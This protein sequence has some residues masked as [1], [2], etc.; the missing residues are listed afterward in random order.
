[1]VMIPV[2][3]TMNGLAHVGSI[4]GIT[5][6]LLGAGRVDSPPRLYRPPDGHT[7]AVCPPDGL[8]PPHT[9]H[10]GQLRWAP[11]GPG[12]PRVAPEGPEWHRRVPSGTDGPRVAPTG[13]EWHRMAPF[14]VTSWEQLSGVVTLSPAGLRTGHRPGN[15]A[16]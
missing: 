15:R 3:P 11:S 12:G 5:P 6:V 2:F 13:P 9:Y 10:S 4:E 14:G 1:M 16:L 8:R 7:P